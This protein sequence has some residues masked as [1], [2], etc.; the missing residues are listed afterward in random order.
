LRKTNIA[1]S[2]SYEE[3]TPKKIKWMIQMQSG[4]TLLGEHMGE[5]SLK[6]EGERGEYD[7]ST[8][9]TCKKIE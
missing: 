5:G 3:C 1:C 7:Q 8:S 9:C 6:K 2:H 4:V